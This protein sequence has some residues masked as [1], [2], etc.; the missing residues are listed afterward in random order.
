M[1]QQYVDKLRAGNKVLDYFLVKQLNLP[2]DKNGNR[3][4]DL[5]LGDK[6][7]E[8]VSKKWSLADE[9]VADFEGFTGNEIVKVKGLVTDWNGQRQIKIEKIRRAVESDGVEIMDLV[10]T[11]PEKGEDMYA[12]ILEKAESVEDEDYRRLLIKLLS[13]NKERLMYWPAAQR[14]HHAE[15]GGLLYH[16]KRMLMNGE[17][18]CEVYPLL[19][20]DLL[21]TGVIIHD[22]E[23]LNEIDSNELGISPGYSLEGQLLGHIVMGVK[24]MERTC[25]EL[26]IPGE[27]SLLL[28]HMVLTHHYEPEFGSP[29]KPLLPEAE[30]LHY[31][32]VIDAH[33]FDIEQAMAGAE[34]GKFS[35]RIFSL[36]NRRFYKTND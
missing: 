31:L 26:N 33:M 1:K 34:P 30:I 35:D 32:D 25:A 9:E 36:D 15:M 19:K 2:T 21:L 4:L 24:L 14:L 18:M 10:K 7:G 23:K 20:R 16:T 17:R 5:I 6:T 8:I 12:F 11:A 27:K 22:M 28:Q 13:D 3:Y 29:K